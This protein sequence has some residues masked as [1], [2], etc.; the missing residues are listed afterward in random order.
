MTECLLSNSVG[1][2]SASSTGEQGGLR[3][4]PGAFRATVELGVNVESRLGEHGEQVLWVVS[5]VGQGHLV[6]V[7]AGALYAPAVT[8]LEGCQQPSAGL[9][10]AG[11]LADAR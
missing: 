4:K 11:E 9:E 3:C 7:G 6:P 5:V 10:Y 1:C 8:S 2:G